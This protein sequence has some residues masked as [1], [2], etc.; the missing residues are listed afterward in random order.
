MYCYLLGCRYRSTRLYKMASLSWTEIVQAQK[1]NRRELLLNGPQIAQRIVRSGLDR[2]L[3]SLELLNYLE[4]ADAS[5]PDLS[6]DIGKLVNLVNLVLRGNKLS[7]LPSAV[8]NLKVLRLL[9]VSS[10]VLKTLPDELGELSEL[11]TLD[12]SRNDLEGLPESI[13]K[14]HRLSVLNISSNKIES[15]EPLCTG[16]LLHLSELTGVKNAITVIPDTI[17]HLQALKKLDLSSNKIAEA[18][19]SLADCT[20]LKD[21]L[22]TENPF[23]DRRLGKLV[24]QSR[25]T[26]AT[27][28]Y[29]RTHGTKKSAPEEKP[30]KAKKKK[31]RKKA[32]STGSDLSE[33]LDKLMLRVLNFKDSSDGGVEVIVK[34]GVASVRP[35]IVCCILRDVN[36]QKGT[37][38]KRFITAQNKL[39]DGPLCAKRTK[40]TIATHDLSLVKFP[41]TYEVKEPAEIQITPLG[42]NKCT[43]ADALMT[44]LRKEADDL[45]K[46]SKRNTVSGIHK[47]LELLDG[48][49]KYPCLC[50]R[51]G[52]VISFPPITN[53]DITKISRSS[54]HILIEVTSSTDLAVCKKVMDALLQRS[55]EILLDSPGTGTA[56]SDDPDE[57]VNPG[58]ADEAAAAT[59][60]A[61]GR[62]VGG[63]RSLVVEQVR[64]SGVEGSLKVVYPSRTD[65]QDMTDIKV[66]RS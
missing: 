57:D 18:P 20:K 14:L 27:L 62:E 28:D 60:S 63:Q 65:L 12:A 48:H 51:E 42:R 9:D 17:S 25:G 2:T 1:E 21:V 16:Q 37:R 64:V 38:F 61:G 29:I 8:G 5:L 3:Y 10:N 19:A 45:R 53:A 52:Q 56:A 15:L 47:Y 4:I 30:A 40:A 44:Q 66:I 46:E 36:F 24:Q 7:T 23:R 32:A 35:F 33:D 39:H 31:G 11:H 50:D 13:G 22:L 54:D 59:D 43:S 58:P 55:A 41:L 26:K 34:E 6:E 49:Q